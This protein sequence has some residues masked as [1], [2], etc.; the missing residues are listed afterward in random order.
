MSSSPDSQG[1]APRRPRLVLPGAAEGPARPKIVLPG[2]GIVDPNTPP[3]QPLEEAP[4]EEIPVAENVVYEEPVEATYA[5][6]EVAVGIPVEGTEDF[7]SA[8]AEAW[9]PAAESGR[10]PELRAA[11]AELKDL[12]PRRLGP[13]ADWQAAGEEPPVEAVPVSPEAV[14]EEPVEFE[15]E[16]QQAEVNAEGQYG[17]QKEQQYEPEYEEQPAEE[18]GYVP[19]AVPMRPASSRVPTPLTSPHSDRPATRRVTQQVRTPTGQTTRLQVG[20]PSPHGH[21]SQVLP[22][23][24]GHAAPPQRLLP[25]WVL[26][27]IGF[28]VGAI[29]ALVAAVKSP[30]R[31]KLGLIER[32]KSNAYVLAVLKEERSQVQAMLDANHRTAKVILAEDMA[33]YRTE[34][35]RKAPERMTMQ[36][37]SA[38]IKEHE[39]IKKE[40]E[41]D[42][43]AAEE[44]AKAEEEKKAA[45][46]GEKKE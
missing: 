22:I 13:P 33:E 38:Q 29:A 8:P 15:Q 26:V 40:E 7:L 20:L 3:P 19:M 24:H 28:L 11:P 9:E 35:G 17:E 5:S 31:D 23:H 32:T 37:F 45:E 16:V 27:V 2:I 36:E 21:T 25:S 42:K 41:E 44:D 46:E 34:E 1:D 43:K 4:V 6:E 18:V 10:P 14:W 39:E 30:L 12:A